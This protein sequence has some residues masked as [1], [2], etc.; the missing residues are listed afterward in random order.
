MGFQKGLRQGAAQLLHVLIQGE[1][2]PSQQGFAG[3]R[4][5]VGMQPRR[6]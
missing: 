4:V 5:A 3:Q 6:R 2:T 1:T